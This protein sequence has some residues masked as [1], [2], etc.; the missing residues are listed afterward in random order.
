MSPSS[1]YLN[2]AHK[3]GSGWTRHK[4]PQATN[5]LFSFC[6]APPTPFCVFRVIMIT[7][8]KVGQEDFRDFQIVSSFVGCFFF[9]NLILPFKQIT[10]FS[11]GL[12]YKFWLT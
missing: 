1:S 9:L 5:R 3:L 2:K 4:T 10:T 7:Q 11:M 6:P 12:F 8:S